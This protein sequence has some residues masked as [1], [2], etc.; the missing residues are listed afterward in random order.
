MTQHF[1]TLEDR[2]QVR[3]SLEV[4]TDPWKKFCLEYLLARGWEIK[5]RPDRRG[6]RW[7]IWEPD[8]GGLFNVWEMNKTADFYSP[9]FIR[10]MS[11][12]VWECDAVTPALTEVRERLMTVAR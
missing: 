6:T 8:S 2:K 1:T 12:Q 7:T 4:L 9:D 3:D 5:R 10:M 11:W